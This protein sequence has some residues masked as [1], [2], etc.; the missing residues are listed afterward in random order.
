MLPAEFRP[1]HTLGRKIFN[2]KDQCDISS[3]KSV[4]SDHPNSTGTFQFTFLFL[5]GSIR[6]SI[7]VIQRTD[8]PSFQENKR[9]QKGT[10]EKPDKHL[11]LCP[12]KYKMWSQGK[13]I[14]KKNTFVQ[15]GNYRNM[16]T[17]WELHPK[18]LPGIHLKQKQHLVNGSAQ[19]CLQEEKESKPVFGIWL[20]R[21]F[22][23]SFKKKVTRE[24]ES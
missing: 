24:A 1:H 5:A 23:H 11:P 2:P 18:I 17:C 22:I 9:E 3:R 16:K 6:C 20:L 13:I 4:H 14:V 10:K 15:E 8:N 19:V 12:W 7:A 21:G